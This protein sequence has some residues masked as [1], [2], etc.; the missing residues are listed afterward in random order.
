MTSDEIFMTSYALSG[1]SIDDIY[2][3]NSSKHQVVNAAEFYALEKLCLYNNIHNMRSNLC[4]DVE[5]SYVNYV[6]EIANLNAGPGN[7]CNRYINL[8]WFDQRPNA[9]DTI[10]QFI[11]NLSD[12]K[13]PD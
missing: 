12:I 6:F 2:I 10:A 13:M 5:R 11:I 1:N 4:Q 3:V 8:E 9:L 7:L